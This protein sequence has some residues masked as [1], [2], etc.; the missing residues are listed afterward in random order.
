MVGAVGRIGARWT[1]LGRPCAVGQLGREYPSRQGIPLQRL[2]LRPLTSVC[3]SQAQ[4]RT[5]IR[6]LN[7]VSQFREGKFDEAI[8]TFIDLDFNPAKVVALYPEAVSGRL[9]V[10]REKWIPLYGGP[11]PEDDDNKSVAST[12]TKEKAGHEKS[13]ADWLDAV[14]EAGSALKSRLQKSAL[15]MLVAGSSGLKDDDTASVVSKR[16]APL[17]GTRIHSLTSIWSECSL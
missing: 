13:A 2:L 7:A 17:H 8:D 1:I 4:R 5:R 11:V 3:L 6:A 12:D 10:P 9:A 16:K 15:G 14:A